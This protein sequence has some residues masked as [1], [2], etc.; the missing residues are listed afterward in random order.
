MDE[1]TSVPVRSPTL[2]SWDPCAVAHG[3]ER[4]MSDKEVGRVLLY[5]KQGT[6]ALYTSSVNLISARLRRVLGR[7]FSI[8]YQ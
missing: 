4:R 2:G 1:Y 5:T 8:K 6:I 3:L 7:L